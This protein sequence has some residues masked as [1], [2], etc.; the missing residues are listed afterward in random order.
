MKVKQG[1]PAGG[2]GS[3]T[4]KRLRDNP[5]SYSWESSHKNTKLHHNKVYTE[6]LT[7]THTGSMFVASGTVSPSESCLVDSVGH[8]LAVFSSLWL[9]QLCTLPSSS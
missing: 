9:L 5:H 4:G 6:D 7:Q 2:K 1:K 8:V 3:K